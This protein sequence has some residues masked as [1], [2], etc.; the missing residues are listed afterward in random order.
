[1][2]ARKNKVTLNDNWREKIRASMLVN[3]LKDHGFGK[4]E[5]PLD[6][7]QVKAIEIVLSR[8][9]PTL[10]SVTQENREAVRSESEIMQQ[11]KQLVAAKPELL[12][13][14]LPAGKVL[15]SVGSTPVAP[16]QTVDDAS[17]KITTHPKVL[18]TQE[19][20]ND[21]T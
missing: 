1:M 10:S 17:G 9:E 4:L 7:T 16:Q 8:L 3:R 19:N 21:L 20:K 14:L 6:A 12:A 11:I 15:V 13:D 5:K 18:N 2:A